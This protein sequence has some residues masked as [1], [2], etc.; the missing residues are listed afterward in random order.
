MKVIKNMIILD[1]SF[2]K[3]L[4]YS[5]LKSGSAMDIEE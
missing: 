4:E 2:N 1:F 5:K 3:S